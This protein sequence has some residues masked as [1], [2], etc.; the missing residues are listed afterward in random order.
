MIQVV[1]PLIGLVLI[2]ENVKRHVKRFTKE[3]LQKMDL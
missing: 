3:R 1:Y 2:R